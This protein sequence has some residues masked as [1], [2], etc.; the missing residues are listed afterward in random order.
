MGSFSQGAT[1]NCTSGDCMEVLNQWDK[2]NQTSLSSFITVSIANADGSSSIYRNGNFIGYKNKR[3]YTLEEANE[4]TGP[5][6][7]VSIKYR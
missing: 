4:V 7:R 5:V 1:L 3:I 6:N 2:D